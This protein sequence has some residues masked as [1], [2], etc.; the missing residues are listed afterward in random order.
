MEMSP[1]LVTSPSVS[2]FADEGRTPLP[3]ELRAL[4]GSLGAATA[5]LGREV[6][7][8]E[9]R[10]NPLLASIRRHVDRN[11]L[12]L[13][14][15][16]QVGLEK[17]AGRVARLKVSRLRTYCPVESRNLVFKHS[18]ATDTGGVGRTFGRRN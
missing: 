10:I 9:R 16:V 3:F 8:L 17:A 12:E 15:E 6:A 2:S 1:S 14:F 18:F 13:L 7:G 5:V 4:D 11:D